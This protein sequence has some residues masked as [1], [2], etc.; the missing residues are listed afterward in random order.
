MCHFVFEGQ[1]VILM[2][3]IP[4]FSLYR[5]LYEFGQYAFMG[6]YMGTTGMTWSDLSDGENGMAEVL[7]IIIV[8]WII[9]LS[10]AYYLD[11]FASSGGK[12]KRDFC[13][14]FFK[15]NPALASTSQRSEENLTK[16]SIELEK[17]DIVA[18]VSLVKNLKGKSITNSPSY[19]V[20]FLVENFIL[21]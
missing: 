14:L 2:E 13:N 4:A 19:N 8:E 17:P 21:L 7:V 3:L 20:C 16:I 18:E 12:F 11:R 1:W 5:G 9:F 15:K 6:N 10:S